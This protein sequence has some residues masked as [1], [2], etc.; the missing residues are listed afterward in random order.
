MHIAFVHHTAV[1]EDTGKVEP[2]DIPKIVVEK[3]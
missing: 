2:E 1:N 3:K